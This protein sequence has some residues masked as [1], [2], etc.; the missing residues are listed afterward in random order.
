MKKKISLRVNDEV[1]S[2]LGGLKLRTICTE[3]LCPNISEC[4]A[5]RR[6]TF[7][8]LGSVCTRDCG[9]C[10]VA[11]GRP[12]PPDPG[13][14]ERVAEACRRLGLRHAVVTSPTRDDLPDGGAFAFVRTVSAVRQLA[15]AP[16]VEV[17]IPD[18]GGDRAALAA[19]AAAGPDVIAHNLETVERLYPARNRGPGP[20]ADYRRSLAV[21]AALRELAPGLKTKSGLML[22]LGEREEEVRETFADLR[23]AGCSFLS[24]GQYLPP[25]RRHLP[26]RRRYAQAD[27][28]RLR[29]EALALGFAHVESGPFVRSSY[30]A[31]DYLDGE[32]D[33]RH[34]GM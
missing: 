26:Q 21:L 12:A 24:L 2:L 13:E 14:P 3:A 28:D 29:E 19:V 5:L 18:F 9:F 27:F 30:R 6:A 23:A 15:P 4:F 34:V 8:V 20:G 1:R 7:L 16:T 32:N 22:G 31:G 25:T 10:N 33:T 11:H 17:L